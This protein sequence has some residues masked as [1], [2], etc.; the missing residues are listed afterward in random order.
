MTEA[1]AK[2]LARQINH[3]PGWR[4]WAEEQPQPYNRWYI[5]TWW[6]QTE[7]PTMEGKGTVPVEDWEGFRI[8]RLAWE[9]YTD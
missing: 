9:G 5:H 4:A 1:A 6:V 2:A 7:H 8:A 3:V